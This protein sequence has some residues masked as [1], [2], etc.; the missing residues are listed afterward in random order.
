MT[1]RMY[2]MEAGIVRIVVWSKI[3]IPAQRGLELGNCNE[4]DKEWGEGCVE[5]GGKRFGDLCGLHWHVCACDCESILAL[6]QKDL[7]AG[8][9]L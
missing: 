1:G 7:R 2:G 8:S 3:R 5:D 4:Y 9:E 6:A